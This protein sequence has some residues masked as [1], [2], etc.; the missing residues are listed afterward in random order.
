MRAAVEAAPLLAAGEGTGAAPSA[1]SHG[2]PAWIAVCPLDDVLPDAG[3]CALVDG[4]QIAIVRVGAGERIFAVDNFDPFSK[5]FV[6]ARGIVGD[7]DGVPKITSPIFKQ[8]FDL[9]T[10]QCLDDPTVCLPTYAVRVQAGQIEVLLAG[11]PPRA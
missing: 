11:A 4:R 1:W 8:G 2:A 5:A 7:K 6:I 9:A 3:V 10:G